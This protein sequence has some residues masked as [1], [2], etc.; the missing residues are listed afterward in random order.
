MT[1]DRVV[2]GGPVESVCRRFGHPIALS[3]SED[4]VLRAFSTQDHNGVLDVVEV[5]YV[6]RGDEEERVQPS[7]WTWLA[8]GVSHEDA[9]VIHAVTHQISHLAEFRAGARVPDS[10]ETDELHKS[11]VAS[12]RTSSAIEVG[13]ASTR[14]PGSRSTP[15]PMASSLWGPLS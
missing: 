10:A 15:G 12:P 14:R 3:T 1:G 4:V 2:F 9:I 11:M 7:I 13:G 5:A 6:L 8:N